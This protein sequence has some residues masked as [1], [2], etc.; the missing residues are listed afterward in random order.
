MDN[1]DAI[2]DSSIFVEMQWKSESTAALLAV[3]LFACSR[4]LVTSSS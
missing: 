2:E 1:L 4:S 3:K